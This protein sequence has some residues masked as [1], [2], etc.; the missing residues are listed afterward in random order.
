V[1]RVY[2]GCPDDGLKA[3]LN[4]ESELMGKIIMRYPEAHSTYFPIENRWNIHV[5][6]KR[7]S[8]MH[9]TKLGALLEVIG[10][11]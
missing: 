5:W 2:N 4:Y 10:G 9:D 1:N 6:G 11:I 3:I 8:E 7:L